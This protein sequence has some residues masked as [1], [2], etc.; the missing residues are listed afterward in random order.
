MFYCSICDF[1]TNIKY[2]YDRHC[3]TIKHINVVNE[4][5]TNNINLDDISSKK[6]NSKSLKKNN[7][8]VKN[9]K[10]KKNIE[11]RIEKNNQND[12]VCEYC[13][14]KYKHQSSFYRHNKRCIARLNHLEEHF[15]YELKVSKLQNDNEKK[16]IEIK[17]LKKLNKA[18]KV[19]ITNN[20]NI[21]ISKIDFLN[22]NFNNVISIETFSKNY[23]EKYGLT[24]Q[25]AESLLYNY[26]NNSLDTCIS[27]F[28]YFF[29]KSAIRQY[30]DKG[31]D[32][33]KKD[34]VLPFIL[35]DESLRYH[36][37]KSKDD[38]WD[39]TTSRDNIKNLVSI[40][41]QQ[42]FKHQNQSLCLS[43][44]E[45]KRIANGVLKESCFNLLSNLSNPEYYKS[46]EI[47]NQTENVSLVNQTQSEIKNKIRSVFESDTESDN[48][49]ESE[50]ESEIE[51]KIE[52]KIKTKINFMD[53]DFDSDEE[54]ED[55]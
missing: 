42:V 24:K 5:K 41:D 29:R 12:I 44:Y 45:K 7:D 37:E 16:D 4:T 22:L 18:K 6:Q 39:R 36:F 28:L 11:N 49:S 53:S 34:I 1:T 30:K 35:A 38:K 31:F 55:E 14:N 23:E 26:R 19:S 50:S 8:I 15:E 40:T 54:Y 33:A 32:I 20:N 27:N 10:V 3:K 21:N 47:E 52:P 46:N 25:E 51:P 17:Y 43:S 9:K 2:N 13:L 48:E